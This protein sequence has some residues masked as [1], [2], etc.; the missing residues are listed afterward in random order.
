MEV[1]V[2]L[3]DMNKMEVE[4][5]DMFSMDTFFERELGEIHEDYKNIFGMVGVESKGILFRVKDRERFIRE[6]ILKYFKGYKFIEKKGVE[7]GHPDY[8][9]ENEE[10]DKIYIELKVGEDNIRINQLMWFIENKDKKG[11]II[12]ICWVNDFVP[13]FSNDATI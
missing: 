3:F 7:V 10:G 11:K 5:D 8:V 1:E 6:I 4:L 9:I 13:N 2:K 12:S